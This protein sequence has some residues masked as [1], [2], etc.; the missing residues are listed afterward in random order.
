MA[1]KT[2][3]EGCPQG[4][5]EA[6]REKKKGQHSEKTLHFFREIADLQRFGTAFGPQGG[7]IGIPKSIFF[8]CLVGYGSKGVIQIN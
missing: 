8:V 2:R 6:G 7:P 3:Q 4:L 1:P 5:G